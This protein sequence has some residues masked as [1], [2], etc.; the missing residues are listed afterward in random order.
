MQS[1]SI[2]TLEVILIIQ[3]DCHGSKIRP[4]LK[5]LKP[6]FKTLIK[7]A[8]ELTISINKL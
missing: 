8:I 1:H 7:D 4:F 3:I 5:T 2:H 6:F